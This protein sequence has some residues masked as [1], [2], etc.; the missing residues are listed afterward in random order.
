MVSG[1]Q[2]PAFSRP[3][4]TAHV[5]WAEVERVVFEHAPRVG[6]SIRFQA[7]GGGTAWHGRHLPLQLCEAAFDE[8]LPVLERSA[9]GGGVSSSPVERPDP[10]R[11]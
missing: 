6:E 11:L 8:L 4:E 10:A 7:R 2:T 5:R 1:S 9:G 3:R